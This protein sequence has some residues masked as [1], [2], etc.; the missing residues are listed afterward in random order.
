VLA[1]RLE[2]RRM[3][4]SLVLE[5]HET[6]ELTLGTARTQ[7]EELLKFLTVCAGARTALSPSRMV[8]PA[9]HFFLSKPAMYDDFCRLEF[10]RRIAHVPSEPNAE[11]Y[12]LARQLI[13]ERFGTLNEQVWPDVTSDRK[14]ITIVADCSG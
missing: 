14:V 2:T 8:D 7:F 5:F 11:R 9:W 6:Q 10:G 12:I 4:Q 1:S 13:K 3:I